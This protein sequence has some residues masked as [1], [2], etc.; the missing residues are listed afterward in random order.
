M[1]RQEAVVF[2]TSVAVLADEVVFVRGFSI[3][4]WHHFAYMVIS[5][6]LLGFG[7]SGT[8]LAVLRR[9]AIQPPTDQFHGN[10]W[11]ALFAVLFALAIPVAF[12]LVQGIPFDPFMLLWD[13]WQLLYL[14]SYYLIMF[15]P[16]FTAATV[17]GLVLTGRF[18]ESPRLYFYNL[19][20]SAAG[21]ALSVVLL[22]IAPVEQVVVAVAAIA[23]AA[24]LLAL[25][26]AVT[27]ASTTARVR[28]FAGVAV[29]AMLGVLLYFVAHPPAM[30]LSQYKGLSD[31]STS[32][33]APPFATLL[34]SLW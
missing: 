14:G 12:A 4:Q 23:Q 34:D 26:D 3:G 13:R 28:Q 33:K 30:R 24:A 5:I 32:S 6:A 9:R 16:F 10:G 11:I 2:L 27:A 25:L 29:V 7:A 21:A 18:Q 19:V 17:I 31:A 20:G 1:K 22:E 8:L 15:V